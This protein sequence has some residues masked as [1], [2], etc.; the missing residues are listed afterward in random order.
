MK[1][2][3]VITEGMNNRKLQDS[4]SKLIFGNAQL[5]AQFLRDYIDIPMLKGIRAED[6]SEAQ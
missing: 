3:Q 4:S 6:I 1:K 5:C 2:E